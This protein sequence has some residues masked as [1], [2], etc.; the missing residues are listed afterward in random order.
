MLSF[1]IKPLCLLH[2]QSSTISLAIKNGN[3]NLKVM[4]KCNLVNSN[5]VRENLYKPF[6]K[7]FGMD[8]IKACSETYRSTSQKLVTD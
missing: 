6:D 7:N 2:F 1:M 3:H 8:F 4:N 5:G